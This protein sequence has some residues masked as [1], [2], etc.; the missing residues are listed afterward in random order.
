MDY[1]PRGSGLKMLSE[2]ESWK[3]YE[4][5]G[6]SMFYSDLENPNDFYQQA[7]FLTIAEDLL[8]L[9]KEDKVEKLI[10]LSTGDDRKYEVFR[11]TFYKL[12][13][14]KNKKRLGD[15]MKL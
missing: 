11:E 14:F 2:K 5:I 4:I 6:S 15:D 7:P 8:K 12:H 10:F 1:S 9:I 13:G 3:N